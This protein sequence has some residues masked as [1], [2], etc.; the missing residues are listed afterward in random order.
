MSKSLKDP[1]YNPSPPP[2][3]S[4]K[5]CFINKAPPSLQSLPSLNYLFLLGLVQT[6][7]FFPLVIYLSDWDIGFLR[8]LLGGVLWAR[9]GRIYVLLSPL[10]MSY[11][12]FVFKT[13]LL[14]GVSQSWPE[15]QIPC[16]G[17]IL[18]LLMLLSSSTFSFAE[19]FCSSSTT[20]FIFQVHSP[21]A[22]GYSLSSLH[23][24]FWLRK[25]HYFSWVKV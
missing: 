2:D 20:R 1:I 15:K 24:F 8:F 14:P 7:T 19:I 3:I 23:F 16:G 17:I 9:V 4:L 12:L 6:L 10:L 13:K 5:F 18:L 21:F 11:Y 25:F 22:L